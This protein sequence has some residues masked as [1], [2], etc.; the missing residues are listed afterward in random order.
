MSDYTEK[1]NKEI[2]NL[3][4]KTIK[5]ILDEYKTIEAALNTKTINKE[6][7]LEDL[8]SLK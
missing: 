4:R 5:L 6:K 2:L 7:I 8:E 3:E 1:I